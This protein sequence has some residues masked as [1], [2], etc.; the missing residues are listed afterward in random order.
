MLLR[1]ILFSRNDFLGIRRFPMAKLQVQSYFCQKLRFR[2]V[3][4]CDSTFPNGEVAGL[5]GRLGT[6]TPPGSGKQRDSC[7]GEKYA[8]PTLQFVS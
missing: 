4:F 6:R 8:G 1:E 5:G 7:W 3:F 2:V